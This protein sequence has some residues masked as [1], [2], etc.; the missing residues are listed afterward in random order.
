[1]FIPLQTLLLRGWNLGGAEILEGWDLGGGRQGGGGGVAGRAKSGKEQVSRQ[2]VERT[3]HHQ[4]SRHEGGGPN[5]TPRL[6][7][8]PM[9]IP[10]IG[11]SKAHLL[12][13][14]NLSLLSILGTEQQTAQGCR[15][16]VEQEVLPHPG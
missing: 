3:L 5:P 1:M 15:D 12:C 16:A 8:S 7:A 14:T 9:E 6:S 13:S 2:G 4:E 11:T 10:G